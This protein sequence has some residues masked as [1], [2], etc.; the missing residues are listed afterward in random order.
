MISLQRMSLNFCM[1][2]AS[3]KCEFW[4]QLQMHFT[5]HILML[6]LCT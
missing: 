1:V 4:L 6:A 5:E 3:H 2:I